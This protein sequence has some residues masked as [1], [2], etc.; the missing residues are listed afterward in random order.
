MPTPPTIDDKIDVLIKRSRENERKIQALMVENRKF[1]QALFNVKSREEP[2]LENGKPK[3]NRYGDVITEKMAPHNPLLG[4]PDLTEPVRN[5]VFTE[6]QKGI[7][8][9]EQLLDQ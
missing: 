8:D 6:A 4:Q 2:V 9:L 3:K 5:K 1:A 7:D